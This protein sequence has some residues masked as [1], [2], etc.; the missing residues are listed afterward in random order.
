[1]CIL[2]TSCSKT[3]TRIEYVYGP[4]ENLL[5]TTEP[6]IDEYPRT[7]DGLAQCRID[8]L[9]ALMKANKDKAIYRKY[10]EETRA[11]QEQQKPES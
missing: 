4:E 3:V 10:I 7:G 8:T 1:M 6:S 2:L 11:R 5:H 9:K